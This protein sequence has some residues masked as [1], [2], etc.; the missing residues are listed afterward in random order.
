MAFG[1]AVAAVV[2]VLAGTLMGSFAKYAIPWDILTVLA[3]LLVV[4]LFVG[5][6]KARPLAYMAF[7]GLL[8]LGGLVLGTYLFGL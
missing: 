1:A 6:L 8:L 4:L 2:A 7:G 3:V 5:A